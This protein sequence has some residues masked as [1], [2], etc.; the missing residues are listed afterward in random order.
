MNRI[1]GGKDV[2]ILRRRPCSAATRSKSK[3]ARIFVKIRN[4]YISFKRKFAKG[5][6]NFADFATFRKVWQ[7]CR[8]ER[9][10]L[11]AT[12]FGGGVCMKEGLEGKFNILPLSSV[13]LLL[14]LLLSI[15]P[16]LQL[17]NRMRP[18]VSYEFA[19]IFSFLF[20]FFAKGRIRG[21]R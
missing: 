20:F 3:I 13:L 11:I 17:P 1:S 4:Y 6:L 16:P 5:G 18:C 10:N 2:F 19:R 8:R 12:I 21:R 14:L 15:P 9:E 7:H